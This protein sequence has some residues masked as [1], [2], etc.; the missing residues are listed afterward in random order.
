MENMKL[1]SEQ[2]KLVE[3]NYYLVAQIMADF[4]LQENDVEDWHGLL[5][6]ELC[7]YIAQDKE[8]CKDNIT[9]YLI[10]CF[11]KKNSNPISVNARPIGL[12]RR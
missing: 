3:N 8:C 4:D 9:H 10:E 1:S 6:E 5:S 12:I 11:R 2:R 7:K